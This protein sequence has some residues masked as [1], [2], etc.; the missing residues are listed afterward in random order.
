[1]NDSVDT[2]LLTTID[3]PFNPHHDWDAWY[4]WDEGHGYH[5]CGLL[6]RL[7]HTSDELSESDQDIAIDYAMAEVL[8]LNPFGVHKK[9]FAKDSVKI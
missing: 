1:M 2:P 7:T 5:T 9:I 3:N 6:A 8:D 4:Q